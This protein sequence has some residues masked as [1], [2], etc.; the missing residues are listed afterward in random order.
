L[1]YRLSI[2]GAPAQPT[3]SFPGGVA[4]QQGYPSRAHRVAW[5][6]Q[7]INKKTGQWQAIGSQGANAGLKSGSR[8]AVVCSSHPIS[9]PRSAVLT[10]P[11][12]TLQE[13]AQHCFNLNLQ[14][15]DFFFLFWLLESGIRSEAS[16]PLIID[17]GSARLGTLRIPSSRP[18]APHHRI[19]ATITFRPTLLPSHH[20]A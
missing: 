3:L 13:H 15:C 12:Y 20:R 11:H 2:T 8:D 6:T 19:P 17:T 1:G 16:L 7:T 4:G 14:V 18:A 9:P 10:R 5:G